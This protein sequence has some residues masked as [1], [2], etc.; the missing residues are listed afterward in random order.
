MDPIFLAAINALP[1]SSDPPA[2]PRA[3]SAKPLLRR[4][5]RP[6][7]PGAAPVR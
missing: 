1:I 2:A 5:K 6:R 7:L 3:T 4:P